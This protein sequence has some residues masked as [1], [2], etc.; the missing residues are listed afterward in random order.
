MTISASQLPSLDNFKDLSIDSINEFQAK[1][2]TLVKGILSEEEIAAYRPAIVDAAERYNTENRKLDDRDTYGKAFLQI[3]NLWQVDEAVKKF[4]LAKRMAKIAADLI[5]V[6]NVRLYHDQALF[7]EPGGGPTPW[8]QDQYYWPIDTNNTVTMWMPLI[9]IDVD[10][11]MLTFASG[12]YK[13]GAVFNHEISDE[14]EEAFDKYVKDNNFPISRAETMKAGDAT[15]HRGFTIHQAPGNKS[16]QLRE[17]MTVIYMADGA[18]VIP[19]KNS[20][21]KT[22][23]HKWLMDKPFGELINSRLNPLLL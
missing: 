15:W 1:G 12:S 18:R 14:S 6:K 20:Q 11:G 9:D 10:M 5:G 19:Y 16:N 2:H 23:H 17:V 8:H 3:M 7:K 13:N 21:Q 22:D 4:V